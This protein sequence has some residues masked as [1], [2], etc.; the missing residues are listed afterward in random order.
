MFPSSFSTV[1]FH[2]FFGLPL[3][4]PALKHG[5]DVPRSKVGGDFG[6]QG[7]RPRS[8]LS[9]FTPLLHTTTNYAKNYCNR[10][11]NVKVIV[12]NVVTYFWDTV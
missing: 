7:Y 11:L 1:L 2:V 3:S 5:T 10:L 4:R 9:G 6:R 8:S 12:E